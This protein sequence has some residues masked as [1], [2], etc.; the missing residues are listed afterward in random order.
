MGSVGRPED[1]KELQM[2]QKPLIAVI[3]GLVILWVGVV[4]VMAL[5]SPRNNKVELSYT[6]KGDDHTCVDPEPTCVG[7]DPDLNPLIHTPS[8][9]NYLLLKS[10]K[11]KW[12]LAA[13]TCKDEKN[14][15]CYWEI[16]YIAD[17]TKGKVSGDHLR[18]VDPIEC[19]KSNTKSGR[20]D[21]STHGD[22]V[23]EWPYQVTVYECIER[24]NKLVKGDCLC[25]SDPRVYI[26]R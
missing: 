14:G 6:Y 19:G 7:G 26:K 23:V 20:D 13:D 21:H 1:R 4:G 8:F 24:G 10:K 9:K 12:R 16:A 2:Q 5:V 15:S 22:P 3:P 17:D 18:T 25:R 11:A